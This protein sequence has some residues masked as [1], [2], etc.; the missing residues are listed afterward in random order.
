MIILFKIEASLHLLQMILALHLHHSRQLLPFLV[1]CLSA[2]LILGREVRV[3]QNVLSYERYL[4]IRTRLHCLVA[5]LQLFMATSLLTPPP[6]RLPPS[7]RPK[8]TMNLQQPLTEH[9]TA[10]KA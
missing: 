10:A 5:L 7:P 3:G 1:F 8:M 4:R 6:S 2:G 9:R